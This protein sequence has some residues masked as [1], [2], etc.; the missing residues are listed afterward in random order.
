MRVEESQLKAFILDAGLVKPAALKRAEA[1]AQSSHKTLREVLLNTGS[2]KEEEIKRLEAYILGIPF[3]DLSRETIRP[4]VLRLIPEP[5]ARANNIVAYRR[6]RN[7][8]EVAI[9]D[10]HHQP[11]P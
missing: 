5:L 9:L 4:E 2:V 3:V 10:P 11:P 6:D 7:E 8:L 1:E